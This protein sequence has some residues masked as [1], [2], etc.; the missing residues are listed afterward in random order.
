MAHPAARATIPIMFI[1][2]TSGEAVPA[3]LTGA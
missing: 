2:L 3:L 1:A